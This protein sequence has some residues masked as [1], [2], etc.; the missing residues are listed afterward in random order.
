MLVDENYR[1]GF[2]TG[3]LVFELLLSTYLVAH[4]LLKV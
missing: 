1:L 3:H 4:I 2:P